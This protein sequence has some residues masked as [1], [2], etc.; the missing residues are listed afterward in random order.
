MFFRK[1]KELQSLVNAS[2]KSLANAEEKIQEKNKLI[3]YQDKQIK[4]LKAKNTDLEN[5]IEI[6]VNNLSAQ[7]KKLARP[8]NQN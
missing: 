4:E 8:D 3:E 5:N 6:L 7:K 2:R 1:Y